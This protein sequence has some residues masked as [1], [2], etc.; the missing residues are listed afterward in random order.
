M[1]GTFLYQVRAVDFAEE[2]LGTSGQLMQVVDDVPTG[3]FRNLS[4]QTST[5]R[6]QSNNNM[7]WQQAPG[8]CTVRFY[9]PNTTNPNRIVSDPVTFNWLGQ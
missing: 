2:P 3:V 8:P 6:W 9:Y 5:Q 1:Q 7:D 4:W